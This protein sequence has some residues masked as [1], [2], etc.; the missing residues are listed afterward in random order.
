MAQYTIEITDDEM[1][2]IKQQAAQVTW[3]EQCEANGDVIDD[4]A[5]GNVDDAY[6]GGVRAGEVYAARELLSRLGIE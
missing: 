2:A 5:G 6:D 4:F 3:A 1:A